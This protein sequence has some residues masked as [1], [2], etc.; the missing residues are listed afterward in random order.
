[1]VDPRSASWRPPLDVHWVELLDSGGGGLLV[2]LAGRWRSEP[3]RGLGEPELVVGVGEAPPRIGPL[4]RAGRAPTSADE[5]GFRAAFSVP[6]GLAARAREEL[7]LAFGDS[8]LLL[9]ASGRPPVPDPEPAAGEVIDRAVLAERRARR[10]EQAEQSTAQRASEAEAAVDA[11]E[12]ELLR[13]E[14]RMERTGE[15]RARLEDRLAQAEEDARR[16]AERVREPASAGGRGTAL[17]HESEL[18]GRRATPPAG[19]VPVRARPTRADAEL[20]EAEARLGVA[21]PVSPALAEASAER[22][23]LQAELD[24]ARAGDRAIADRILADVVA[25]A[26]ELRVRLEQLESERDIALAG[27]AAAGR[28]LA[29]REAELAHAR[30]EIEHRVRALTVERDRALAGQR[31]EAARHEAELLDGLAVERRTF[32]ARLDSLRAEWEQQLEDERAGFEAEAARIEGHLTML[33]NELETTREHAREGDRKRT[34]EERLVTEFMRSASTAL[35]EAEVRLAAAQASAREVQAA[36]EQG[37]GVAEAIAAEREAAE[38]RLGTAHAAFA[39]ELEQA[40][41]ERLALAAQLTE[42]GERARRALAVAHNAQARLAASRVTQA[43]QPP[44]VVDPPVDQP[45]P[46]QPRATATSSPAEAPT[47]LQPAAKEP[48]TAT[49]ASEPGASRGWL[50][51]ALP[52]LAAERPAVAV[53]LLL[54]LLKARPGSLDCALVLAGDGTWSVA[55]QWPATRLREIDAPRRGTPVLRATPRALAGLLAA[56]PPRGWR[57]RRRLRVA[58]TRRRKLLAALAPVELD[59][60]RLAARGI[61]LDPRALYA[62]LLTEMD[63][64]WT[65]GHRFC[66][67]QVIAGEGAARW[68][69]R[70]RDGAAPILTT[71]PAAE[72][73]DAS[74]GFTADAFQR[75]LGGQPPEGDRRVTVRGDVASVALLA[76]WTDRVVREKPA[77][78]AG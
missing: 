43:A 78:F 17:R 6:A 16:A 36:R 2:R 56:G 41:R 39:Q 28:R 37:H 55:G 24:A 70:I 21:G 10:A 22:D 26:A 47:A 66:V 49:E 13:F 53:P 12:A 45:P 34:E 38:E 20:L 54:G 18:A 52:R 14:A 23:R 11:L 74:V 5:R 46:D 58:G 57:N 69:V 42:A 64:A 19:P 48:P 77:A 72:G 76:G 15:D 60:A 8:L 7:R 4:Q 73:V 29:E 30:R 59:P 31:A 44:P 9:P 62:A 61:L 51:H 25:D 71:K 63:P 27:A 65:V 33:R 67:E 32:E 1:M 50:A 40:R 68:H 3:P 35:R 75:L